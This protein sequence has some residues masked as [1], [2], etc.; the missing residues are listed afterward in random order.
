VDGVERGRQFMLMELEINEP[1]LYLGSFPGAAVRFANA[2]ELV[3]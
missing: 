2:I 1:Y 3:L